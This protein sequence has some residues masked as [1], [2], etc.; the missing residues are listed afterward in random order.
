M[1]EIWRSEIMQLE[2]TQKLVKSAAELVT[3]VHPF[4]DLDNVL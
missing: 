4:P 3:C 2:R 1:A